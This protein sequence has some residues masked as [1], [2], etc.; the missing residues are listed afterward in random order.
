MFYLYTIYS[1]PLSAQAQ[2]SRSFLIICSLR[3]NSSLDTWTVVRL[4]AA[5]FKPLIFSVFG[6]AFT[7]RLE[8]EEVEVNLRPTIS[9]PVCL[10]VGLPSG[11]HDHIFVFCL[12]IAGF[13]LWD[14]LSDESMGL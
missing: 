3:Y 13:L 7:L 1:R 14:A 11:A 10:D 5:K 9:R 8:V 2:Y 4:T 6:F 12:T